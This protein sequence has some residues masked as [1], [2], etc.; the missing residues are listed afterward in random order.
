MGSWQIS[1]GVA[2]LAIV[3]LLTAL[4]LPPPG[5]ARTRHLVF[6]LLVM[7]L[8]VAAGWLWNMDYRVMRAEKVAERIA[9]GHY[10]PD[11]R[12]QMAMEFFEK[13]K[14]L[15]PDSYER[16]QDYYE[17]KGC[18]LPEPGMENKQLIECMRDQVETSIYFRGMLRAV[19]PPIPENG[20]AH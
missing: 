8:G 19:A 4:T 10:P 17:S 2:A 1:T 20:E 13:N 14:S 18:V 11:A 16:M 12:I 3:L 9:D 5:R 15:Y 6:G 7:A